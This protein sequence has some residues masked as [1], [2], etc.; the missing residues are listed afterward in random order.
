MLPFLGPAC[1][2]LQ[3]RLA[4]LLPARRQGDPSLPVLYLIAVL[5][6]AAGDI[7]A[8][9]GW[10]TAAGLLALPVFAL[11]LRR[12]SLAAFLLAAGLLGGIA[13]APEPP[14]VPAGSVQPFDPARS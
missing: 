13:T 12:A 1:R 6:L 8:R 3:Q 11:A 14:A 5:A 7:A 9:L 10:G 2:A 4:A